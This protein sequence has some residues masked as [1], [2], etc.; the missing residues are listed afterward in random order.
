MKV[1]LSN[2]QLWQ[3]KYLPAITNPKTY[4][5]LFGGAGCFAETQ[6]VETDSGPKEIAKIN[7]GEKVLSFNHIEGKE[8][9]K[10]V[11][12][13]FEFKRH[14]DRL[15]QIK[16]KDGTVIKVTENHKFFYGGAYVK[17]K[18]ILLSLEYGNRSLDE[19]TGIF[20]L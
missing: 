16:M 7:P 11:L 5:I 8:E 6:K 2:P 13:R 20:S 12:N 4:N 9:F 15:I 3:K 19:N 17:I 14:Q 1:D 10:E 18:D